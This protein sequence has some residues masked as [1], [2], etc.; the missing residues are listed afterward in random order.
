M[1][2]KYFLGCVSMPKR[3][4]SSINLSFGQNLTKYRKMCGLTQQ[5]IADILNL[6]RTTYTKYETGVSEPSLEI[7]KKIVAI[8]G[9][10]VNSVLGVDAFEKN[11]ADFNMPMYTLT[12]EEQEIVGIYRMLSDEEK[13]Q[14]TDYIIQVKIEKNNNF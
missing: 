7:L 1:A 3:K 8:L 4:C 6:N 10:D 13:K 2:H 12:K 14:V 9:V 5:Q 11:L